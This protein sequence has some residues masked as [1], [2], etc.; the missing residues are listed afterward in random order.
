[1][2]APKFNLPEINKENSKMSFQK[3]IGKKMTKPV[4]FMGEET[5]ISK[6]SVAQIMLVQEAAKAAETDETKGFDILK[7]IIRASAEGAADITDDQ[8]ADFPMDELS[9]LSNTIMVFSGIDAG[10]S[11]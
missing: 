9:N 1:M 11:K 6:L 8:F 2:A 5:T 10:K 7:T 3:L 4:K